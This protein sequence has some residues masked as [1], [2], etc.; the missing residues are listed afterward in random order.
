MLL[1]TYSSCVGS[2]MTVDDRLARTALSW[3]VLASVG[4]GIANQ[5]IRPTAA[6]DRPLANRT[7]GRRVRSADEK[8]VHRPL[9]GLPMLAGC[10][11]CFMRNFR[12][13]L[14]LRLFRRRPP[15]RLPFE[16]HQFRA[17]RRLMMAEA[18]LSLMTTGRPPS[19]RRS[20][21]PPTPPCS[22]ADAPLLIRMIYLEFIY[23]HVRPGGCCFIS[24]RS[25]F[26]DV[27]VFLF[28]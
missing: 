6:D 5:S 23:L 14:L 26:E 27:S 22:T 15:S 7:P 21:K 8:I 11:L 20:I 28:V 18:G 4:E 12:L 19:R 17:I 13:L 10:R 2:R 25:L 16:M 3:P 24:P 1:P 9:P